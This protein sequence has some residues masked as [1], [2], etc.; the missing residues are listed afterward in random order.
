MVVNTMLTVGNTISLSTI[1]LTWLWK[2]SK[3]L[4]KPD[5][6]PGQFL[7]IDNS[8]KV[9]LPTFCFLIKGYWLWILL[10]TVTCYSGPIGFHLKLKKS[11]TV[12]S[13]PP[14][15]LC[16]KSLLRHN[17]NTMF[18]LKKVIDVQYVQLTLLIHLDFT[19]AFTDLTCTTDLF[20]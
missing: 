12:S 4:L 13:L 8:K 19:N 18:R 6:A 9:L 11:D 2:H 7:I 17:I 20:H 3:V 15:L 10:P 5:P 14:I 1:L 16:N